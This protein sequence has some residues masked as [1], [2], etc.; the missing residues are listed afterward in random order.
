M[1]DRPQSGPPTG[2]PNNADTFV[3]EEFAG[4]NTKPPRPGIKDGEMFWSD[5]FM[6]VGPN[7]LRTLPGIGPALFYA[8]PP[9][10]PPTPGFVTWNPDD[11]SPTGSL[12][13]LLLS[14]SNSTTDPCG[15][16]ALYP[17]GTGLYYWEVIATA[18]STS[19]WFGVA[20]S[21]ISISSVTS[22]GTGTLAVFNWAEG[23]NVIINGV[24]APAINMPIGDPW[25]IAVNLGAKRFWVRNIG[26]DPVYGWNTGPH[27]SNNGNPATPANGV[28][29]STQWSS[30][31]PG[32]APGAS[33]PSCNF[34]S[35]PTGNAQLTL[36]S[37]VGDFYGVI[38]SGF[39]APPAPLVWGGAPPLVLSNGG[40]TATL[41]AGTVISGG[42]VLMHATGA[43]NSSGK[44]YYEFTVNL[45]GGAPL[46]FGFLAFGTGSTYVGGFVP[47]NSDLLVFQG[48]TQ[49][50]AAGDFT[51]SPLNAPVDGH[52]WAV[53][54]DRVNNLWWIRDLGAD[55]VNNLG[56]MDM[57]GVFV[58]TELLPAGAAHVIG[59]LNTVNFGWTPALIGPVPTGF[60]NG[61]A[62]PGG[63]VP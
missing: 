34:F 48:G 28:S 32:T 1:S 58:G 39:S 47:N 24:N 30:G 55:P 3:F 18:V 36:H 11:I 61:W 38:P 60:T 43:S 27:W 59:L 31:S 57:T 56:G 8:N 53:C 21:S 20:D 51:G 12:D 16:R 52:R 17:R 13:P 19:S 45:S 25:A 49:G 22:V 29:T 10:P 35:A 41:A 37:T 40:K 50:W 9:T 62:Y 15:V 6:P 26:L 46:D 42:G 4:L 2:L 7:N 5:G 23:A 14:L 44:W 33:V 63:I 54:D